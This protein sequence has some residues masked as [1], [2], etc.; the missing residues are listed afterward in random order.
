MPQGGSTTVLRPPTQFQTTHTDRQ[1]RNCARFKNN[2]AFHQSQ[3]PHIRIFTPTHH[4]FRYLGRMAFPWRV[5]LVLIVLITLFSPAIRAQSTQDDL[6][7]ALLAKPLYLKG[8]WQKDDLKFDAVGQL[9]NRSS[10][11]TFTLCGV[12]ITSVLPDGNGIRLTGYR[13]GLT[14]VDSA[15]G[16]ERHPLHLSPPPH[17]TASEIWKS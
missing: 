12:E 13:V 9:Q 6:R 4:I 17:G 3:R 16:L 1:T 11:E 15:H 7:T 5:A 8:L 14:A 2:A 10:T